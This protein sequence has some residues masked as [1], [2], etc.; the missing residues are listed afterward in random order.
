MISRVLK[1]A[2]IMS[3]EDRDNKLYNDLI[4][5][6][7]RIGGKLFGH[8]FNGTCRE[9]FCLDEDTWIWHEE[10][11]DKNGNHKSRTTRYEVR[12]DSLVKV[13]NGKYQYL[14]KPETARFLDAVR[15]YDSRVTRELYARA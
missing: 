4:R 8:T 3:Q 6:E 11:T 13:V 14:S 15:A 9:F 1:L 2:G 7:G 12:P 5:H 10:W